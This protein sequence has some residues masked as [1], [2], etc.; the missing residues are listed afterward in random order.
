MGF[1]FSLFGENEHRQFNY[2]PRYYDVEAEER[3]KFFGEHPEIE[4][5]ADEDTI[6]GQ[7][8]DA[9]EAMESGKKNVQHKPGRYISGSFRD[10]HYQRTAVDTSK[11]QRI[12][13]IISLV[14]IFIVFVYIAK[15]YGLI[16]G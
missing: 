6:D 13:G 11:A 3:R 1:N 5:L 4:E 15:F 12:I 8:K 16:L 10:G 2:K 14:L 9:R 7:N